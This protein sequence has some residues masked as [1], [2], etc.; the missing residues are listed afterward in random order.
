MLPLIALR[1]DWH[2]TVIVCHPRSVHPAPH[3][4]THCDPLWDDPTEVLEA[5]PHG[6]TPDEWS[7][8]LSGHDT[9]LFADRPLPSQPTCALPGTPEKIRV[10]FDRCR[11]GEHIH[12]PADPT[13][14]TDDR[15]GWQGLHRGDDAGTIVTTLITRSHDGETTVNQPPLP[16][17]QAKPTYLVTCG[18]D[19]RRVK[20]KAKNEALGLKLAVQEFGLRGKHGRRK[21]HVQQ[22]ADVC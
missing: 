14:E 2:I 4:P 17:P 13:F 10:M 19:G 3:K 18:V 7:T 20:V 1:S 5:I 6:L 21:L 11:R 9:D 15:V 16:E 12:H 22:I 8:F